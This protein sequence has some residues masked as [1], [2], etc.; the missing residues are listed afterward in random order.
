M[1]IDLT[2]DYIVG[3]LFAGG[4][5]KAS[6]TRLQARSEGGQLVDVYLTRDAFYEQVSLLNPV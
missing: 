4:D 2:D 1:Q 3:T 5:W 6:M